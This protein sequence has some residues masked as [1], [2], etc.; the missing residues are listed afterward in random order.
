MP[1]K[2]TIININK[3]NT[4]YEILWNLEKEHWFTAL[5]IKNDLS[6]KAILLLVKSLLFLQQ[7]T[8]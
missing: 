7:I 8:T 1:N 5:K 2:C 6:P 4:F 3:Y